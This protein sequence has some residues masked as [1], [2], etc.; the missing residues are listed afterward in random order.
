MIWRSSIL[1]LPLIIPSAVSAQDKPALVYDSTG[2]LVPAERIPAAARPQPALPTR[3]GPWVNLGLGFGTVNCADFCSSVAPAAEV[4]AG[5]AVSPQL[6]LGVG[7]VG[8]T[9]DGPTG[10]YEGARLRLTV[11]SVDFRARFYPQRDAGFF[12]TGG[13]GLGITRLSDERGFGHTQTGAGFLAGLGCDLWMN[14]HMSLTPFADF[15]TTRAGEPND[16]R[17]DL[18]R[19]GLS[20]TFH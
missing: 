9:K 12:L 3:R 20:V 18:W 11:G 8:W 5:W 13:L 2:Q 17:D 10:E 7:I 6:S 15:S 4:A 14:P 16:L 1:L 19:L